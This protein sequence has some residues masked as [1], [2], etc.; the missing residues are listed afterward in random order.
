MEINTKK[1]N[2]VVQA[3]SPSD[4]KDKV[5]ATWDRMELNAPTL[6]AYPADSRE[7]ALTV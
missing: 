2:A 6:S 5:I 4:M 7:K 1:R 3:R